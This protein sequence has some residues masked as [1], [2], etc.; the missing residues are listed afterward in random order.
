M[1]RDPTN[2]LHLTVDIVI[3]IHAKVID[4][5]GGLEGIRDLSLLESAI[6]APQESSICGWQ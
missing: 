6:A 4:A 3:E 1:I 5:F 2:V